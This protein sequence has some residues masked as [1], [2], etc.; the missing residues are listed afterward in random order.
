LDDIDG[1]LLHALGSIMTANA[2]V[3]STKLVEL[4]DTVPDY[5]DYECEEAVRDTESDYRVA[6]GR[7]AKAWGDQLLELAEHPPSPLTRNE[8]QTI[9]ILLNLIGQV[10]RELNTFQDTFLPPG[11]RRRRLRLRRSD[12]TILRCMEQSVRLMDALH[13]RDGA[14]LWLHG[15]ASGMYRR[16]RR[17]TR[18]L[19]RRNELLATA[20]DERQD[21]VDDV[22][23]TGGILPWTG[24]Q[25]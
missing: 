11:D 22:D 3:V 4:F 10:F 17:L 21:L 19:H 18:E 6:L 24:G 15:S 25:P 13:P 23:G 14:A 20:D 9:D 1:Q 12:G 8:R 7:V 5:L 16:L 2:A